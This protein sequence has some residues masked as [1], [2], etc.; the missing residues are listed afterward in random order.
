MMRGYL[1]VRNVATKMSSMLAGN[2]FGLV[3]VWALKH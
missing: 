3:A 2:V 1:Y